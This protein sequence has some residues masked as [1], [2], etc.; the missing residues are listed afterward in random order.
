MLTDFLRRVLPNSGHWIVVHIAQGGGPTQTHITKAGDVPAVESLI[1]RGN[2]S[3]HNTY[4]GVCSF[5]APTG[6]VLKRNRECAALGEFRTLR[7][8][9][10]VG[11]G[12]DYQT[13]EDAVNAVDSFSATTGLPAPLLVSSGRGLH[14]YFPMTENI[15]FQRWLGLASALRS[16]AKTLGLRFD[17]NVAEPERLLRLPTSVNQRSGQEAY[18]YDE[19][20]DSAV[21]VLTHLLLPYA[22]TSSPATLPSAAKDLG[23]E[24]ESGLLQP[25]S[26]ELAIDTCPALAKMKAT[27]GHDVPEPLWKKVLDLISNGADT[28]E[29]KWR[30]AQEVSIGYPTYSESELAAKLQQSMR[31]GYSPPTCSN[32]AR[33]EC[34]SCPFRQRVTSPATLGVAG[35]VSVIPA[36]AVT[37]PATT[38]VTAPAVVAA[39][40]PRDIGAEFNLLAVPKIIIKNGA[41]ELC[42]GLM[43]YRAK[44]DDVW[45]SIPL[46][47]SYR[48]NRAYREYNA[49]AGTSSL[50]LEIDTMDETFQFVRSVVKLGITSEAFSGKEA[51]CKV[52]IGAG[53]YAI[54][55]ERDKLWELLMGFIQI[56]QSRGIERPKFDA[57]GWDSDQLFVFGDAAVNNAGMQVVHDAA[58]GPTV[59][60]D[61]V[62][63]PVYTC[64]GSLEVQRDALNSML[65]TDVSHLVFA[66]GIATPLIRYT[67]FQ[68]AMVSLYSKESGVGKTALLKAIASIWGD[69]MA[70]MIP[71]SS[72]Q[73]AVQH[74]IGAARSV[75]VAIDEISMLSDQF[76]S[77]LLYD[78]SQGQGKRRMGRGGEAVQAQQAEW[79]TL[80]FVTTNNPVAAKARAVMPDSNAML[81]R[82]LEINLPQLPTDVLTGSP[83]TIL[84]Q[85][86]GHIGRKAVVGMMQHDAGAWRQVIE[87]RV[88]EWGLRLNTTAV[89]GTDR[90]RVALCAIAEIGAIIGQSLGVKLDVD[91]VEREVRKVCDYMRDEDT[92]LTITNDTILANYI[93]DNS[94][95]LGRLTINN[96]IRS[97]A[98]NVR[99]A[100]FGEVVMEVGPGGRLQVASCLLPVHKLMEY[101][102]LKKYNETD[103]RRWL[104]KSATTEM[105]GQRQFM[106][107]TIYSF[108]ADAVDVSP[109]VFGSAS[110][111]MAPPTVDKAAKKK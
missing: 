21:E 92:A 76:I 40:P 105:V 42:N 52:V 96:G 87:K 90:F 73:A 16:A 83:D 102:K 95:R 46:C 1:K 28:N 71:A 14:V 80:V 88:Q 110:L 34:A 32:V 41:Y 6:G 55:A 17:D 103:F 11:D 36:A 44:K 27:G 65:V 33:P 79:Q 81:A 86:F 70:A 93:A 101:A 66:L 56:L 58:V 25:F 35:F 29:V 18:V 2:N 31:Q 62:A 45:E 91:A 8:D 94:P 47:P 53:I 63:V 99:E 23:N 89:H 59:L 50:I 109:K 82:L 67:A 57:I 26:A 10:D 97:V 43:Y 24:L 60:R 106:E 104:R 72:T 74:L 3:K 54:G 61:G 9:I 49:R 30:L 37:T 51:F 48:L 100:S 84:C 7:I 4:Y 69:P 22:T 78:V 5:V 20:E 98:E 15:P 108:R 12:K 38:M 77:E 75:P 85:N 39:K 111:A 64:A 68:G 107:G 19:G 13:F